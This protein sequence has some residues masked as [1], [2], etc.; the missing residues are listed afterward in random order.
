[1]TALNKPS[2]PTQLEQ[3]QHNQHTINTEGTLRLLRPYQQRHLWMATSTNLGSR[4][5]PR[6]KLTGNLPRLTIITLHAESSP[7]SSFQHQHQHRTGGNTL[8]VV[9]RRGPFA[10]P[11]VSISMVLVGMIPPR[12]DDGLGQVNEWKDAA[13]QLEHVEGC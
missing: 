2:H 8:C 4:R 13:S 1:M 12:A 9:Y 7:P 6:R 3:V 11:T 5:D 10:L